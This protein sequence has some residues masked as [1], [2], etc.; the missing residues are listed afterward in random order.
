LL[1]GAGINAAK[2]LVLP[3]QARDALFEGANQLHPVVEL[4]FL[5]DS[6]CGF[7][8]GARAFGLRHERWSP[9]GMRTL[10][11]DSPGQPT[12]TNR[13][14]APVSAQPIRPRFKPNLPP[15]MMHAGRDAEQL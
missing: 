9:G 6:R 2:N 5:L 11:K 10:S 12:A 3:M 14:D 1:S 4:K 7:R 8:S 15:P 13:K